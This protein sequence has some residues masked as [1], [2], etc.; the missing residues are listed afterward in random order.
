M[1]ST[2]LEMPR[3]RLALSDLR[4]YTQAKPRVG[5]VLGSGLGAYA[6]TLANKVIV[7]FSEVHGMPTSTVVGH[8]GNFVI[9]DVG[10]MSVIA[11]QGRVH[12]YEGHGPRDAVFGVRLMALMGAEFLL[13]TNAAGGCGEGMTPG[14][15]MLIDDHLN[16][17]GHSPLTGPAEL[18]MG[19]R[20]PDMTRAYDAKL[21]NLAEKISHAHGFH[22][23]RG[24]YAGLL[25]PSYETPAEI[26]MLRTIG[27]H[28]VGM[29]TVLE[30]I[31]ARHMGMRV[32]GLSCITNLAAGLGT[33]ELSH[34]EV[35]E[36]A[37]RV[38]ARFTAFVHGILEAISKGEA[39]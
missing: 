14:T 27:A 7:P 30:V 9:G 39:A 22:L 37:D 24:V 33:A 20:F 21:G 23:P 19:P 34:H 4:K 3:L 35:T 8:A 6:D 17:T 16:L 1:E 18:D 28:A 2:T 10:G 13:V 32:V 29:S 26:R 36:T 12:M 5:L 15:L 25:G 31:A 11:M 38:K